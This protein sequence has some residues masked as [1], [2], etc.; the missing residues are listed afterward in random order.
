MNDLPCFC[1]FSKNVNFKKGKIKLLFIFLNYIQRDVGWGRMMSFG[2]QTPYVLE[3]FLKKTFMTASGSN[4]ALSEC[5]C[6][7]WVQ[8]FTRINLLSMKLLTT[9]DL[10]KTYFGFSVVIFM[11]LLAVVLLIFQ[12]PI[13]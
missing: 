6:F 11:L 8:I 4:T 13:L 2:I 5:E 3:F 10:Q 7:L 1:V 9:I 12:I